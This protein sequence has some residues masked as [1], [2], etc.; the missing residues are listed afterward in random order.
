MPPTRPPTHSKKGKRP[1]HNHSQPEPAAAAT[2]GVQKLKA[3][4]RQTRRL[5]AKDKLAADVRVETERRLRALEA[6][7]AEAEAARK[8]RALAV[9]YHKIKFFERQKLVRKISQTKRAISTLQE[10]I[11]E[12]KKTKEQR[13]ELKTLQATLGELRV[14]LNY[15]LH[16]PRSKKYISLFPPEVRKRSG[17]HGSDSDE[18]GDNAGSEDGHESDDGGGG[19]EK[20]SSATDAQ[21]E[22]LRADIRARMA[23]GE[24]SAE[25]EVGMDARPAGGSKSSTGG[26]SGVKSGTRSGGGKSGGKAQREEEDAPMEDAFFGEDGESD[27]D[28]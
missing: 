6:D 16:Y 22:A 11:G 21:R 1:N 24:L 3:A 18:D 5:L 15:V 8:E 27:G 19:G 7:L 10:V 20:D 17:K 26:A 23:S 28:T 2:P 25:P 9:R 13:K 14:D 12:G 4:L